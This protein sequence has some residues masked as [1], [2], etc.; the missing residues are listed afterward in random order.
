LRSKGGGGVRVLLFNATFNN[1]S[2]ISWRSVLL[3]EE[4]RVFR[5]NH[6]P[7]LVT[8]KLYHILLY[9]V[10]LAMTRIQTHN[11]PIIL[12]ARI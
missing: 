9:R 7:V 3:I 10:H 12:T 5:E 4:I 8:D 6:R 1:I 11:S 2:V